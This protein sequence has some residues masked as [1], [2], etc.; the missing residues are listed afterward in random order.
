M[1]HITDEY[2]YEML[3]KIKDYSIVILRPGPKANEPGIE[4]IIWEHGRRNFALR[5]DGLLS[6]VCPV[7]IQGNVSGIGI[8]N[9]SLEETK[10]IMDDDPGVQAA[11]FEYEIYPCKS[12]PGDSLS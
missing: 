11:V 4:R 10:K 6:I 8:F 3:T 7:T 1:T 9:T 12:F 5:A 2:M